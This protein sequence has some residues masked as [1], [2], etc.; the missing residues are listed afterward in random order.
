MPSSVIYKWYKH[1]NYLVSFW[2]SLLQMTIGAVMQ[3][4]RK[5]ENDNP[6]RLM[7]TEEG[8]EQKEYEKNSGYNI[9]EN[10]PGTR[11][12]KNNYPSC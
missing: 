12:E 8:R 1:Q 4:S 6:L 5:K 2:R 11:V 10:K 9:L 3:T 7:K